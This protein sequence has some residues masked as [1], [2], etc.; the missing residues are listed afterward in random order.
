MHANDFDFAIQI[1]FFILTSISISKCVNLFRMYHVPFS[2]FVCCAFKPTVS[3][4]L[5]HLYMQ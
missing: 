2:G 5:E 3:N 1:F 4:M